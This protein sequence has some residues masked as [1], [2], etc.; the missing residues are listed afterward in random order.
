MVWWLLDLDLRALIAAMASEK[1]RLDFFATYE[2]VGQRPSKCSRELPNLKKSIEE[3]FRSE[4]EYMGT[5][6]GAGG[7]RKQENDGEG[8]ELGKK[9]SSVRGAGVG[10]KG[11]SL[12]SVSSLSRG[13]LGCGSSPEGH[14][15]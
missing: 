3:D 1:T 10:G 8:G 14:G 9:A 5:R 11:F 4:V 13:A 7:E 12:R 6:K 15:G 2:H